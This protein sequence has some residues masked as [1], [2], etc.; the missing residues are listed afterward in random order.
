MPSQALT[1]TMKAALPSP[2]KAIDIIFVLDR[3]GSVGSSNYKEMIK[4]VKAVLSYFSVAPTTT[5]VAVVSFGTDAKVEFDLLE[6]NSEDNNKCELLRTHIPKIKYD[7]KTEGTTNTRG[8]LDHALALLDLKERDVRSF[9]TKLIFTITD[10][11]WNNGGDPATVVRKLQEMGVYM[12]AIGIG[13][14]GVNNYRLRSLGN[15]K[16]HGHE[17]VYLCL[18]FTVLSEVARRFKG[19]LQNND[20]LPSTSCPDPCNQ[21]TRSCQCNVY[22]GD[23]GCVCRLGYTCGAKRDTKCSVNT[24]K[25]T[26]G[27]GQCKNCPTHSETLGKGAT[28]K[29]DCKCIFGYFWVGSPVERC[30][31]V[32]CHIPA[33]D[34]NAVNAVS[35]GRREN[36]DVCSF[37]C[38][39]GYD[40][41][42][43]EKMLTCQSSGVWDA[44][45]LS[46][47]RAT[48]PILTEP[49]DGS[50]SPCDNRHGDT[51]KF[52]CDYSF[53]LSGSGSATTTCTS[54][55]TWSPPT[56]TCSSMVQSDITDQ[57]KG[58]RPIAAEIYK[59][60][61]STLQNTHELDEEETIVCVVCNKQEAEGDEFVEC[62]GC[63]ANTFETKVSGQLDFI[64][65][66]LQSVGC[67]SKNDDAE[68][69][70]LREDNGR[71][72]RRVQK[73]EETVTTLQTTSKAAQKEMS[74]IKLSHDVLKVKVSN[75][76]GQLARSQP[77]SD[78]QSDKKTANTQPADHVPKYSLHTTNRFEVLSQHESDE[79]IRGEE[80]APIPQVSRHAA[81]AAKARPT[82]VKLPLLSGTKGDVEVTA[83][84]TGPTGPS[85]G[86]TT[87]CQSLPP[88]PN[89]NMVNSG[90]PHS[91]YN[92]GPNPTR[93][94]QREVF[95]KG[96]PNAPNGRGNG[97]A[98]PMRPNGPAA[99]APPPMFYPN[100][101]NKPFLQEEW[102][103]PIEAYGRPAVA[104][105]IRPPNWYGPPPFPF[106]KDRSWHGRPDSL[107]GYNE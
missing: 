66:K 30:E 104:E 51:C 15:K 89:V 41:S 73:L 78:V 42:S 25:D 72:R 62:S 70:K 40:E 48:C 44:V 74:D 31:K 99:P 79:Q 18:D 24:Y 19:D 55:G 105:N 77:R 12:F 87:V 82:P 47:K 6:S 107:F 2:N 101:K 76:K 56:P 26:L 9:S 49:Q 93:R 61:D 67:I 17:Y 34:S 90:K 16:S 37:E 85:P 21:A 95:H 102:P 57:C 28:S 106:R 71:L 97:I 65:K 60:A 64:M 38:K 35:C 69:R 23:Y 22:K 84:P 20:Y 4:F 83:D 94:P 7:M 98:P 36:N 53:G 13:K 39:S 68:L 52:Q 1:S 86:A 50:I 59:Q 63:H 75:I 29:A 54:V 81:Q 88:P 32:L 10:G 80:K 43:G 46:C 11:E 58:N 14:W 45:P 3:S 8:A 96:S 100:H 91:K 27:P 33:Y 103:S 92:A 5:R